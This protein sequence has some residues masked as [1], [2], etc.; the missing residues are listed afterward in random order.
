MTIRNH[1]RQG[2]RRLRLSFACWARLRR[3]ELLK[4]RQAYATS[5][6]ALALLNAKH[7]LLG[8]AEQELRAL[9]KANPDSEIAR[10]L[11][12]DVSSMR[13]R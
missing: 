6:L 8:E 3:N 5:H 2:R 1:G 12:A 10:T 4:A 7:G 11:L 9:V 13:H